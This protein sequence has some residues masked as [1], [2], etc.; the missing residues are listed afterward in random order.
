MDTE[1]TN[2]D[3]WE[4]CIDRLYK[5]SQAFNVAALNYKSVLAAKLNELKVIEKATIVEKLA[6]GSTEVLDAEKT[7][8]E[9]KL[10]VQA[11]KAMLRMFEAEDANLRTDKKITARITQ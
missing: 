10:R 9:L 5:N 6:Q 11:G 1:Q 4:A 8:L 7:M 3:K 2:R